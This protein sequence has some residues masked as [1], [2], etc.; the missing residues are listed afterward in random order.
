MKKAV[1]LII[2]AAMMLTSCGLFSG[3]DDVPPEDL[4]TP[5]PVPTDNV[6]P[7][8]PAPVQSGDGRFSLRYNS[9]ATFNP[10]VGT[11]AGNM[12][13]ATLMYEGLFR[14]TDDFGYEPVLCESFETEDCKTYNFKLREGVFMSDGSELSPYDV[15]Y[16]INTA[17]GSS[18]YSSRL[19]NVSSASVVDSRTVRVVLKQADARFPALLDIGIIKD[20][21]SGTTPRGTGPYVYTEADGYV[22]LSRNEFHEKASS[23]PVS[24]IY[25]VQCADTELGERFTESAIDLF[26]DDPNATVVSVRRDHETRYFNTTVMQYIGFNSRTSAVTDSRFRKVVQLATDRD[27]IVKNVLDSRA[28]AAPLALPTF[29]SLYDKTWESVSDTNALVAMSGLL[30]EIGMLDY[31]SDTYLEYPLSGSYIEVRLVFLVNSENAARCEIAGMIAERLRRVGLNIEL[32]ELRYE[33]YIAALKAGDFDIYFGET[34]LPANFDFSELISPGGALDYGNMATDEYDAKNSAFLAARG[35]FAEKNA[36]REL[37]LT[38]AESLPFVPVAYKQY[39]VHSGRN[40]ISGLSP[41]QTGV[42]WNIYDWTI[43]VK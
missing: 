6:T 8:V 26:V 38:L 23:L 3:E 22:Y 15:V 37:C 12:A 4:P 34:R 20:G 13:L 16:S 19:K 36:A 33:E 27:A 9:A 29:Y 25:L 42:F 39:A 14:L 24:R 28:S 35:S 2:L 31:N 32:Q 41:S 21:T 30:N 43:D 11:D 1:A 17:K 40:E 10:L 5:D 18:R 7:D